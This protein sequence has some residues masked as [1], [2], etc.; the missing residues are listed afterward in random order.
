MNLV[1][2][3]VISSYHHAHTGTASPPQMSLTSPPPDNDDDDDSLDRLRQLA[4]IAASR[5]P[6]LKMSPSSFFYHPADIAAV[7]SPQE[8]LGD[9]V[10]TSTV[11]LSPPFSQQSSPPPPQDSPI[12]LRVVKCRR[13]EWIMERRDSL[14]SNR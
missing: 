4:D 9:G 10:F 12:D 11:M 6:L 5:H 3:E 1:K 7:S 13:Q 14:D 8:K 2:R